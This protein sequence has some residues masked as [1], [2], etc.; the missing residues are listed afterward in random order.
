MPSNSLTRSGEAFF[1]AVADWKPS[2]RRCAAFPLVLAGK[3]GTT[4]ISNGS[5]SERACR[6]TSFHGLPKDEMKT[7]SLLATKSVSPCLMLVLV[8]ELGWYTPRAT[9]SRAYA[10]AARYSAVSNALRKL[11]LVSTF[12]LL[13]APNA[14]A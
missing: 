2:P 11:P 12:Q 14:T 5:L 1:S 13:G 9:R 10:A 7:A 6:H 3:G 8:S 4:R